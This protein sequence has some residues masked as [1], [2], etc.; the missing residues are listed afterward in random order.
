MMS[1]FW[2][3]SPKHPTDVFKTMEEAVSWA[4]S[5]LNPAIRLSRPN[6]GA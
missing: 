6:Q 2:L 4:N 5:R 3:F 1:V